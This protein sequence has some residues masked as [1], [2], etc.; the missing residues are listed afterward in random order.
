MQHRG[1]KGRANQFRPSEWEPA[2]SHGARAPLAL[3]TLMAGS[4]GSAG[5]DLRRHGTCA[6]AA[7]A[8]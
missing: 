6:L 5:E 1:G 3:G 2:A 4:L 8:G 7:M